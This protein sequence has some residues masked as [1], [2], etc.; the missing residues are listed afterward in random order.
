ML[1]TKV[2]QG[3]YFMMGDNRDHSNDSRFWGT[4]AYKHIVGTPWI[5][6]FSWDKNKEVRWDRVFR[7]VEGLEE[8]MMGKEQTFDHEKG[9]Y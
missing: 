1:P 9:I 2:P 5:I 4:V 8:D 7:T 6:Y 3:E